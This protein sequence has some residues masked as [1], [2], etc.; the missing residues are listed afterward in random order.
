MPE[1]VLVRHLGGQAEANGTAIELLLKATVPTA[2]ARRARSC[3]RSP[4]RVPHASCIALSTAHC[5]GESQGFCHRCGRVSWPF[6]C[7]CWLSMQEPAEG[8]AARRAV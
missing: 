5:D 2:R 6:D 1:S 4:M 3:P 7:V 8:G